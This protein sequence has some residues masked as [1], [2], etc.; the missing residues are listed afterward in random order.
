[1]LFMLD[2]APPNAGGAPSPSSIAGGPETGADGNAAPQRVQ[3]GGVARVASMTN[4]HL[5][6]VAMLFG[7]GAA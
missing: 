4:P 7:V 6:H 2:A 5:E 3:R 1:V